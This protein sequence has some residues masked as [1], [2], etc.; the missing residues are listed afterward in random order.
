MGL[1]LLQTWAMPCE[2]GGGVCKTPNH[3]VSRG[4]IGK[5]KI[6]ARKTK[7]VIIETEKYFVNHNEKFIS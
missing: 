2:G 4:V 3:Y 7:Y 6:Y 1:E 5:D